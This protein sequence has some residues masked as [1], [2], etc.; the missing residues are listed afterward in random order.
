[1]SCVQNITN[2]S[3]IPPN[4]QHIMVYDANA[5]ELEHYNLVHPNGFLLVEAKPDQEIY[6]PGY[7][8]CVDHNWLNGRLVMLKKVTN[9]KF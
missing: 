7:N 6:V 2:L 3:D 4:S 9:Y 8:V 5:E 1:M